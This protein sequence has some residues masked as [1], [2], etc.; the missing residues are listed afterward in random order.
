MHT[1]L[2]THYD[3]VNAVFIISAPSSIHCSYSCVCRFLDPLH[4]ATMVYYASAVLQHVRG[5][6]VP[7]CVATAYAGNGRADRFF[8][9]GISEGKSTFTPAPPKESAH[10]LTEGNRLLLFCAVVLDKM[11]LWIERTMSTFLCG[12]ETLQHIDGPFICYR[13]NNQSSSLKYSLTHRNQSVKVH[14]HAM[15]RNLL[16][17]ISERLRRRCVRRVAI[18]ARIASTIFCTFCRATRVNQYPL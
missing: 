13:G 8:R 18:D 17:W 11:R 5:T 12:E 9:A 2:C 6:H 4:S 1:Q 16:N 10:C 15:S 3:S 7:A 14:A